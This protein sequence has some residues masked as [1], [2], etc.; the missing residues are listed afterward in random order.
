M[1][2]LLEDKE[3]LAQI[4][5]ALQLKAN[6]FSSRMK[7]I[8]RHTIYKILTGD[9]GI[10]YTTIKKI[11]NAYPDVNPEFLEKGKGPVLISQKPKADEQLEDILSIPARLQRI[12]EAQKRIEAKLDQLLNQTTN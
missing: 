6:A 5:D 10:T 3:I 11:T 4:L 2:K 1:E 7:D 12:E 9:I 8:S